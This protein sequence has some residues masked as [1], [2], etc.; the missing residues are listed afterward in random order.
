M[1]KEYKTVLNSA[2][3]E[4][5]EKKSRFISSVRPVCNE[6]EAVEFIN[7]IRSK[8]WDAT[9]NVYAYL[10][11]GSGTIQKFSDDGE[12]SGTAGMPVLETI[13]RLDVKN[14]VV[15]VTR[16]FG[17]TLLGTEGLVRAYGRSAQA[18]ILAAG[19]VRK[20]LCTEVHV[21]IEYDLFGKLQN[22]ILNRR[23][24]IKKTEYGQDIESIVFVP[25]DEVA[26]FTELVCEITGDRALVATGE[27]A[28]VT[29]DA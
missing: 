4:I 18:G 3:E 1:L 8:Y 11:D 25:V 6:D 15:V 22:M 24:K 27:Q 16:Y 19:I 10:I 14:V 12:P 28:Y 29:I 17:G 9:H 13:K 23:Y 7:N 2:V 21:I 26:A 20:Q 5:V